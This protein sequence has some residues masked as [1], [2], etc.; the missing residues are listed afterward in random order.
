MP[1]ERRDG[2]QLVRGLRLGERVLGSDD[3]P[4]RAAPPERDQLT[5][6]LLDELR[7]E[8]HQP[9]EVEALDADVAADE[10][11]RVDRLPGAAREADS[12][13]D[14]ERPQRLQAGREDRAA[15]RIE[16]HVDVVELADLLVAD[17]RLG[18]QLPRERVLLLRAR[19]GRDAR[20]EMARELDR[21]RARPRRPPRSRARASRAGCAPAGRTGSQ[22]VRN[23]VRN[24]APSA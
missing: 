6:L 22:A 9:T 5:G 21:G 14:A 24:E 2:D 20:A 13:R 4:D 8:A 19:R 17:R 12:D 3:G 11:G 7:L 1:V 16:R 15:D 23:V 10:P 18:A